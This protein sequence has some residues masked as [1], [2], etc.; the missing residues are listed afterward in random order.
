MVE[1]AVHPTLDSFFEP[2]WM[3]GKEKHFRLWRSCIAEMIGAPVEYHY[4]RR[5]VAFDERHPGLSAIK[6]LPFL[7]ARVTDQAWRQPTAAERLGLWDDLP[8]EPLLILVFL[9]VPGGM[10]QARHA[11]A[12][13]KRLDDLDELIHFVG[14]GWH[15]HTH[16]VARTFFHALAKTHEDVRVVGTYDPSG[17]I[18][19]P[20][21]SP[22]TAAE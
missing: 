1:I 6:S 8:D 21:L 12:I 14:Q 7:E 18:D 3:Q 17:T 19:L 20:A 2:S 5:P 13:A 11:E 15:T 16:E 9:T 22:G 10:F 4:V